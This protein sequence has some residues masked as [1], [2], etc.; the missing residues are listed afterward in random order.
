MKK[1]PNIIL[2]MTDQQRADTIRAFG[3]PYMIT[4]NMDSLVKGGTAFRQAYCPGATC[5]ASRAAMFTGMYPHNTGVYSFDDWSHHYTWVEDLRKNGYYC[6]NLGKMHCSPTY[7]ENGFDERRAVENEASLFF[8]RHIPQDEWG[9]FLM[10]HGIRRPTERHKHV[11][12]WMD[13]YNAFEFDY[14]E[15]FHADYYVG[16]MTCTWLDNWDTFKPLFLQIG[17]PGPH[18]PYDPPKRYLDLYRDVQTPEAVYAEGEIEEKPPQHRALRNHFL[19]TKTAESKID[20]EKAAK[21]DVARMRRHYYANITM[22]D[23]WIGKILGKLKE[24][25]MLENSI[26]IFTSDHGDNLGDH[27]MSYKW[28]M[29]DTITNVPLI[30]KDFRKADEAQERKTDGLVSLMDIGPTILQYAGA[31]IPSCMEGKS[32]K[33]YLE[34]EEDLPEQ[35]YV[36][37]EDNYLIMIRSRDYKM[38]YYIDQTYGE[39]YDLRKDPAEL[40][41][42]FEAK[43]YEQVRNRLTEQ[44]LAWL[45]K[46]CY[47]NGGYKTKKDMLYD[48]RWPDNPRYTHRLIGFNEEQK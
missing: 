12:E 1:K 22:I 44:L 33:G 3:Y 39:L 17:F 29:Y 42:L 16:N 10:D 45:S 43:E 34:N 19:T 23:D 38:V 37:S 9:N 36:F 46:S 6:V 25:G 21:E 4:P 7:A 13:L 11:P 26:V 35:E 27:R 47:F 14:E 48:T 31:Q 40:K 28:L 30:I 41:N 15:R 5:I 18:E 24:K 32:L 20:I 2:I 8:E